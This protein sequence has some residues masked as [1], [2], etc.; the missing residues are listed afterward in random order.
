[1]PIGQTTSIP[2]NHLRLCCYSSARHSWLQPSHPTELIDLPNEVKLKTP[3]ILRFKKLET[4]AINTEAVE[5]L[6][7]FS[8]M[9]MSVLWNYPLF[10]WLWTC[11]TEYIVN[12]SLHMSSICFCS[13]T[14][15]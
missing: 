14:E 13:R 12:L 2:L 5:R 9:A 8:E 10:I 3:E 11:V 7:R 4:C 15:S 6:V 1:M